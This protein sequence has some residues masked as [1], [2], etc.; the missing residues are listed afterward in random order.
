MPPGGSACL[1]ATNK[2]SKLPGP[3]VGKLAL[4]R[5]QAG[6]ID[7]FP[8]PRLPAFL[9]LAEH[10]PPGIPREDKNGVEIHLQHVIPIRVGEVFRGR[11]SL[12]AAA[13]HEFRSAA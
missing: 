8:T 6:D 3:L 12:D 13:C 9:L 2:R 4:K 7:D 11:T 1:S 10:M 5:D